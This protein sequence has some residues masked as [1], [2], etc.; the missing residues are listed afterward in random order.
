M[1]FY[2]RSTFVAGFVVAAAV[3]GLARLTATEHKMGLWPKISFPPHF[4][5]SDALAEQVQGGRGHGRKK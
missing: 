1:A 5:L 2:S 3:A 4:F